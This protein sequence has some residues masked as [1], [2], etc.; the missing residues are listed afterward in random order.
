MD[1][2]LAIAA[3]FSLLVIKGRERK[4]NEREERGGGRRRKG[5]EKKGEERR[6]RAAPHSA[7]PQRQGAQN[8]AGQPLPLGGEVAVRPLRDPHC[9]P[10]SSCTT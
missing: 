9:L 10:T 1:K 7:T 8:P 4:K 2:A 6:D 5:R 3:N